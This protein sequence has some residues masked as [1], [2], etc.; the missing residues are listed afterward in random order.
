MLSLLPPMLCGWRI[1]R[2]MVVPDWLHR[3]RLSIGPLMTLFVPGYFL[4]CSPTCLSRSAQQRLSIF[5]LVCPLNDSKM[6]LSASSGVM[7]QTML[8]SLLDIM[9]SYPVAAAQSADAQSKALAARRIVTIAVA[10]KL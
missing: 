9:F 3:K 7:R 10:N 5:N 4:R 8:W 6:L 2:V 1:V